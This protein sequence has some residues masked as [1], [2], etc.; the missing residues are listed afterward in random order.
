MLI[1][2]INLSAFTSNHSNVNFKINLIAFA[3]TL[4]LILN[5]RYDREKFADTD[6]SAY[7]QARALQASAHKYY[8]IAIGLANVSPASKPKRKKNKKKPGR[9]SGYK[10]RPISLRNLRNRK[11]LRASDGRASVSTASVS[12]TAASDASVTAAAA[13][14]TRSDVAWMKC[15]DP[16]LS[17]AQL[18]AL[19]KAMHT[20]LPE[21]D[22][23]DEAYPKGKYYCYAERVCRSYL[24]EWKRQRADALHVNRENIARSAV[25][26]VNEGQVRPWKD[27]PQNGN[28][29]LCMRIMLPVIENVLGIPCA[30]FKKG[31][32]AWIKKIIATDG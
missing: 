9:G 7:E 6:T 19:S 26:Q 20:I 32:D 11:N 10:P 28:T 30:D 16:P 25:S 23:F 15:R 14:D 1:L 12:V 4:M 8:M 18:C 24:V 27:K 5:D 21:Q 31:S 2:D 29:H 17:Q 22:G 3:I 13:S